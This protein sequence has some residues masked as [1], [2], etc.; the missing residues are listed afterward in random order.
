MHPQLMS[1]REKEAAVK[2][3]NL[4]L[5]RTIPT[6][7]LSELFQDVC[8]ICWGTAP[9]HTSG[10]EDLFVSPAAWKTQRGQL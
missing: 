4:L 10:R 1:R 9:P 8:C 5:Y 2:D 3:T 6:L 7:I